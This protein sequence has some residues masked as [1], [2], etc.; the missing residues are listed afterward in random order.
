MEEFGDMFLFMY[1][2]GTPSLAILCGIYY[3]WLDL[4]KSA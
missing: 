2:S 3:M 4:R 1:N